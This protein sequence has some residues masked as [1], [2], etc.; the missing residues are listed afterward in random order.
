MKKTTSKTTPTVVKS[1]ALIEGRGQLTLQESRLV[2]LALS[3]IDSR[4]PLPKEKIAL[5]VSE[6]M[7]V[8]GGSKGKIYEHLDFATTAL[9]ER[10][11]KIETSTGWEKFQWV[12]HSKLKKGEGII[13][14]KFHEKMAPYITELRQCFTK[15]EL[16]RLAGFTSTHALRIYENMLKWEAGTCLEITVD[17]LKRMLGLY[18]EKKKKFDY[19]RFFDF[20]NRVLKPA[21]EQIETYTPHR[22]EYTKIGG[23]GPAGIRMIKF[24]LTFKN[25][26]SVK[27]TYEKLHSTITQISGETTEQPVFN[28]AEDDSNF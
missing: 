5:S 16:P 26:K 19:P 28:F 13:E 24:F 22:L 23:R 6:Y 14:I 12:S 27:E 4:N 18:D 7:S 25:Q 20:E 17:E 21:K 15:I 11:V 1:N 10:V 3:K 2:L 8:F 9:M